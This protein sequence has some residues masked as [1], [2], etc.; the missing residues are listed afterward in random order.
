MSANKFPAKHA[1]NLPTGF[2]DEADAMKEDQLRACIVT[3]SNNLA[4]TEIE[5]AENKD[6]QRL[7]EKVKDASAGYNDAKK[8]QRAKIAYCLHRLEEMGKLE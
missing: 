5:M 8:A 6:L 3:S 7:K 1:K 2:A 4:I